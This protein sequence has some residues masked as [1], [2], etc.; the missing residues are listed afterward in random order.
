MDCGKFKD[1]DSC[2][3]DECIWVDGAKRKY[4][5]KAKNSTKKKSKHSTG[6][7]VLRKTEKKNSGKKVNKTSKKSPKVTNLSLIINELATMRKK[8]F[9]RRDTFRA[10]AYTKA[11]K[12]LQQHF[13]KNDITSVEQAQDLKNIGTHIKSKIGE[14]LQ[15]G[16][17]QS[18]EQVRS[19]PDIELI[20]TFSDIYGIGAKKASEF[21]KE[22]GIKSIEE[23]REKQDEIQGNKRPLLNDKQKLGLK[24][25]ED[26][27]LRIPRNEMLRH[28]EIIHRVSK[29]MGDKVTVVI[30]GSYRRIT[31]D[32]GD[33][34]MLITHSENDNSVYD[35][36]IDKLKSINYLKED[37][38]HGK[39]KYHGLSKLNDVR[40]FR[41][42]DIM[43]TTPEEFPFALLYFTGS[44]SFNPIMRQIALNQGYRLNEYGLYHFDDKTKKV[45]KRVDY[46]FSNEKD[47]F[48]FLK[49]PFIE[50]KK[51]NPS[52]L[53]DLGFT[54]E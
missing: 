54:N 45:G 32:S 7:V 4:C 14:I 26:I 20:N 39:K 1:K 22:K 13:T 29:E 12:S 24:Y 48:E 3:S 11:I 6:V 51:R 15:H 37:L 43:Y 36:F 41:R 27:L 33:I 5:R 35:T 47:I 49:I 16:K 28:D 53:M 18:A 38:I 25:Y 46:K 40:H 42:V 8:E 17:L 34:D 9:A 31:S 44:G 23:L 52:T 30:A 19:D 50:P 2:K 10:T 21:V